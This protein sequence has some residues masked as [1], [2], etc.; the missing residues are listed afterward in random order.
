MISTD[1]LRR[2]PA[3]ALLTLALLATAAAQVDA[4]NWGQNT[5]GVTLVLHEGPR[6]KSPQ[7]T[8]LWYNLIGRGFPGDVPFTLW[9]WPP[10]KDPA[11]VAKGVSFD[12]RGVLVCSGRPGFC[13]GE[14]PDD[15]INIK[16]NAVLGEA[17]RL[18]VVSPDGKI[19]GFAE[20]V[21]FPIEAT[22]KSCKL[23]VVRMSL[24]TD[25][26][27]VRVSGFAANERL[28]LN[29]RT[30]SEEASIDHSADQQGSWTGV[31][32]LP[33]NGQGKASVSV[34]PVTGEHCKV[35]VSFDWGA[36]SNHP[37]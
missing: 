32:K 23:S 25:A 30:S 37:M 6:Q 2:I 11:P 10:D 15:P 3:F 36:G 14:G 17:K 13:K 28:T 12:K 20:A 7:G 35:A 31:V 34:T 33:L 16:A 27:T 22:D 26:V 1:S 19:A 4:R 18:A 29:M 8:L 9:R 5:V 24:A 21:P